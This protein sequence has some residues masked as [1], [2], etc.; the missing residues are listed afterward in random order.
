M[1]ENENKEVVKTEQKES[2]DVKDMEIKNLTEQV[3][4]LVEKVSSLEKNMMKKTDLRINIKTLYGKTFYL[5]ADKSDKI[6][7]LKSQIQEKEKIPVGEQYLFLNSVLLDDNLTIDE[8]NIKETSILNL[9]KEKEEYF[10][11]CS[12]KERNYFSDALQ[13]NVFK[14]IKCL[15]YD[16]RK[17]GDDANTF[18]RKCDDQEGGLFYAIRTT[19][20]VVFGIYVSKPISS[21]G[22]SKT[23]SLQMVISPAHNFAVKSLNNRATYH[24]QSNQGAHFHCMQLRTPFL[25]TDC[26]DIQSCSDF[27]LPCYP[28]GNSS[29]RI[30]ELQVY[31]VENSD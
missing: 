6:A 20:D 7:D 3:K 28:S 18:H 8:S 30:K 31:A 9:M 26:T 17:D 10:S 22:S 13:K 12:A 1:T 2:Q 11:L 27:N 25:S 29:Y 21:D 24:C 23:D 15:L 16:A 19:Q 5:Y 14:K 4:L